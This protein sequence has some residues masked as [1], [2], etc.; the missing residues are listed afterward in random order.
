MAQSGERPSSA[1]VMISQL[2]GSSP[3]SGF[4]LTAQTLEPPSD[5]VS[6]C[7]LAPPLLAL[8]LSIKNKLKKKLFLKG[9]LWGA[10]VAQK[11]KGQTLDLAQVMISRLSP[12][13]GS[14]LSVEPA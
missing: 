2:M 6:P 3:A 1:Q 13:S 5:S 4:V 7:L 12:K 9:F 10:W 14:G 11:V 8:S